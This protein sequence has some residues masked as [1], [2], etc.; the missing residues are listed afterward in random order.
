LPS[1]GVGLRHYAPRARLMLIEAV[2]ADLPSRLAR[3]A[4]NWPGER[5][6]VLLPADVP[7]NIPGAI[8]YAWGRWSAP[9]ELA[10]GLYAGLRA[11]DAQG[12]TVIVCPVPPEDGVGAAIRDRLRKAA[13]EGPENKKRETRD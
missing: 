8:L 4:L 7:S 3:A 9:E 11:L 12:C 1:P 13:Y 2:L 10:H 5:V 6:G